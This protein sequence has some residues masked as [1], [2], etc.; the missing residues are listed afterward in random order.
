MAEPT[1]HIALGSNT[2]DR[3]RA[4][5]SALRRLDGM[6]GIHIVARSSFHETTPVDC[7]TGSPP[8]L[9][10]AA[11]LQ[12]SLSPRD[13]LDVLLR[14]EREAGRSRETGV[15]HA[16]RPLD[17]DLLLFG[18]RVIDDAGLVVPHP[19][20]HERHFVLAPLAEIASDAIHPV[21]KRTIGQLLSR[22]TARES[23]VDRDPV[24]PVPSVHLPDEPGV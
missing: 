7:P 20:L 1:A 21:L 3:E 16:P 12:T 23:G 10:A 8:F 4:L 11:A 15:R 14:V 9:N 6:P 2:G 18:D 19:R 13:L 17:L 5:E 24:A 22:L